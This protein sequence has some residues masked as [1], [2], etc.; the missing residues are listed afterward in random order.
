MNHL[1]LSKIHVTLLG[2]GT[3]WYRLHYRLELW[4]CGYGHEKITCDRL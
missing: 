4:C 3:Q 2:L 1:A